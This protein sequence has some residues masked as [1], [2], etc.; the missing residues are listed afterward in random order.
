L[1]LGLIDQVARFCKTS[2]KGELPT[3]AHVLDSCSAF[4]RIREPPGI[5]SR[6]RAFMNKG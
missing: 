4:S 3:K 2:R 5:Q 1:S 6:M